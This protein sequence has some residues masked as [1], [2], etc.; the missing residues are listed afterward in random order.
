MDTIKSLLAGTVVGLLLAATQLP[1]YASTD[2]AYQLSQMTGRSA[3]D[4]QIVLNESFLTANTVSP[5]TAKNALLGEMRE[6]SDDFLSCEVKFQCVATIAAMETGHFKHTY[7]NNVGGITDS[8]GYKSYETLEEGIEALDNLLYHQY[9]S[10]DG[11]YYSGVTVLDV[12]T[13]Y[14]TNIH[15][16]AL[17]VDV[18]LSMEER[19]RAS[20][21]QE[22]F[23]YRFCA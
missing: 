22:Y 7:Q 6:Y 12:A 20:E 11:R 19:I 5:Y 23:I 4:I 8:T 18:R 3:E 2:T 16:L 15:W 14:N 21:R 17:Y 10:E 1:A 9:L 13:Y